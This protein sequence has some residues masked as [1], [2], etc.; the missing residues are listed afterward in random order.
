V[1]TQNFVGPEDVGARVSFQYEL[2]NGYVGEVVGQFHQWDEAADAY[3]IVDRNGAIARVPR[4]GVKFGK[5]VS[6]PS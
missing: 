6:Q 5:I 1:S 4:A 2:P 3:V